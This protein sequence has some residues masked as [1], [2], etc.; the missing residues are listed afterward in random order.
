[1]KK[2]AFSIIILFMLCNTNAQSKITGVYYLHGVMETASVFLVKP[3]STFEFFF[4]YGAID[5]YGSG[6]WSVSGDKII[7]NSDK[8]PGQ[9]FKM[10]TSKKTDNNYITV[11]ITDSNAYLLNHVYAGLQFAD[12]TLGDISDENGEIKISKKDPQKISLTFEFCPE[13]TSVFNIDKTLNYFEFKFEP[14]IAEVFFTDF[15]LAL[16]ADELTGRHPLL[17]NKIYHYEKEK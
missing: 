17:E 7:L 10:I 16:A 6:K 2:I 9:N 3:D 13:K 12:T 5:R 8:K 1:M 14:W 11:K 4:S 15:P